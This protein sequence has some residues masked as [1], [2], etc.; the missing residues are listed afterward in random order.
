M[1]KI[2]HIDMDAFY[3]SVELRERPELRHLPVVVSSHHPRAVI[4]AASYPAREFGLRSAMA[5]SQARKLCPHAVVIE[6]D[7]EKYRAVSAQIHQIFRRYTALIEP[8]SLDEAYLDVS[9]NLLGI[10]SA[11]E[12]ALRIREEIL[13]TTGLTASAGV[14]PNKF[15]AKI[16]SDWNKPNGI[17]VIKPSKVKDF[18]HDLPLKKI[19]GV[20]KVTQV[21]LQAM[22]M[23]TLG[24]LQQM[25]EAVLAHH[26]GKY[27]RQLF[28]YAQGIDERPVQA[29]RERQQ[30]SRE[31]TFDSDLTLVQCHSYWPQLIEQVWNSLQRKQ[32]N[33]RGVSAKLKLKNFQVLQHSKSFK[34]PLHSQADLT[35]ALEQ[36]LQEMHIPDDFQ[37]RLIGVG[38]YQLAP[39]AQEVQ[40]TLL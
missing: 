3:A 18:I 23:E 16:A 5:M 2:I 36:L 15:L 31:T 37:F 6:P 40:L 4:C 9:D 26:F 12:V 8:L 27:G 32:L 24:D 20:G 25:D 7:F 35:Q 39:A 22:H 13:Q 21:K 33:A 19:P 17:C 38:V 34:S 30:I 28:L 10:P 29:E 11:T 14:A 1:R